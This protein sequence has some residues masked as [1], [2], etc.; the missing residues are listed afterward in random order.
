MTDCEEIGSDFAHQSD[1]VKLHR[2]DLV[3]LK[4]F[5]IILEPIYTVCTTQIKKS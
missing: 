2:V 3:K 4:A 1:T 5:T